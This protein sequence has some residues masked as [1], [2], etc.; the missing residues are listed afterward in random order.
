[1]AT[2]V[3]PAVEDRPSRSPSPACRRRKP[4]LALAGEEAEVL[5]LGLLGDGEAVAAAISRTS[6]LL[7]S[8]SG[9]RRRSSIVGGRAASM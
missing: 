2:D 5:A 9:K 6:G 1:M 4:L 3:R 7:S 8:V